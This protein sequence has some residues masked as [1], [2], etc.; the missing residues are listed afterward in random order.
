L[1]LF[2]YQHSVMAR[3]GFKRLWARIVPPA[4][5]RSTYVLWRASV[6]ILAVL[7]N[8]GDS[9]AIWT[10]TDPR[11]RIAAP[12]HF[13]ARM[14]R[15]AVEH[16][17]VNHF[18]LFGLRQVFASAAKRDCRRRNF[19]RRSSIAMCGIRCIWASDFLWATPVMSVGHCCSAPQPP[20]TSWSASGSRSAT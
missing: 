17:P 15:S 5:E 20:D 1:G 10:V 4:I 16:V 8:G 9:D 6:L 7:A 18:E 2:A 13:L 3:P 14:V 12:G 19:A 11:H